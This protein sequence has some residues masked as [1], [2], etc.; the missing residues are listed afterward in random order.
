MA[1][2]SNFRNLALLSAIFLLAQ[3]PAWSQEQQSFTT[4]GGSIIYSGT[5]T[6]LKI[7]NLMSAN[8]TLILTP[9]E[10]VS[11]AQAIVRRGSEEQIFTGKTIT[12]HPDTEDFSIEGDAKIEEGKDCIFGP[13]SIV[14]ESKNDI[15]TVEGHNRQK[16]ATILYTVGPQQ[17]FY[18]ETSKCLFYFT[19][20][21]N[22]RVLRDFASPGNY[23]SHLYEGP[24]KSTQELLRKLS[25][26]KK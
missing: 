2:K 23:Y 12:Y 11:V 3:A 5:G 21:E 16:P 9:Q 24:Y 18:C 20:K 6:A 22:K 14:F 26:P 7:L 1:T 8:R 4:S 19:K 25:P 17:T 15:M 13:K 10:G